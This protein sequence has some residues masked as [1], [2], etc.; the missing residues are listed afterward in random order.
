MVMSMPYLGKVKILR[1]IAP[2]LKAPGPSSPVS[3][4][5]GAIVAVE[6][7]DTQTVSQLTEWLDN[8]LHKSEQFASK[9]VDGPK[10]P[11]ANEETSLR[12][13]LGTVGE[14]HGRGKEIIDFI[15]TAPSA[16]NASEEDSDKDCS[17]TLSAIPV[18]LLSTYQ[19][20]ASD[21]YACRIPITDAY[22]PTD[23]WQWMATMWRGIIGPDITI[24]IR[25][26]LPVEMSKEKVVEVKEDVKCLVVRKAKGTTVME[27][28]A[29]RRVGFE[30]SEWVRSMSN[31]VSEA[32][33]Q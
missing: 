18:L 1:K 32:R 19:L 26:A 2:P 29:L 14:W 24:Y 6:G 9:V 8:F 15:T 23:H 28:K 11:A 17:G 4:V 27:E 7:E 16:I 33:E 3:T 13:Y 31:E 30:V 20:H 12:Q 21:A 5:R 22:S 10:V 25:D